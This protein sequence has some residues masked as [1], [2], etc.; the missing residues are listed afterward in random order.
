MNKLFGLGFM[1][2]VVAGLMLTANVMAQDE[3]RPVSSARLQMVEKTNRSRI[4]A[5]P[6]VDWSTYT[7]IQLEKAPVSF[8]RNWQRDQN[9]SNSFKVNAKDMEKIRNSLSELFNQVMTEELTKNGGY[10]MSASSGEQVLT[11]KPAIIDLDVA[12][13]DTKNAAFSKQYTDSAGRMTA[14]LEIFDSVTGEL[15]ATVR[16]RLEDPRRGYMQW[17]TSVSNR[18]DAERLLRQWAG[19][20]RKKLDKASQHSPPS[21]DGL[22]E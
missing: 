17:T 20:L 18:A 1:I 12:A 15:L 8:R 21:S 14:E 16:Q 13:P 10:T 4:Y 19:D 6:A 5:N 2:P 7:E 9:S 3:A 11:I 22:T